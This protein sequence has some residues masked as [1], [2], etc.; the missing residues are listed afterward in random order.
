MQVR[1]AGVMGF[2]YGVRRAISSLEKAAHESAPIQTLG[3]VVHNRQVVE[4]LAARGIQPV[5][6]ISRLTCPT[7]AITTH[8]VGPKVMAE[9]QS[10]S[11]E[12]INVTCPWVKRAQRA[13]QRLTAAGFSVLILGDRGHPEVKGV[14]EWAGDAGRATDGTDIDSLWKEFPRRLGIMSQ[15][16]QNP[17]AFDEFVKR[18]MD[19]FLPQ[20]IELRVINTICD[21]TQK[22]QAAAIEL[23]GTVDVIV[24]VGGKGS[25]N[26]RRLAEICVASGVAARLIETAR[27]L[28]PNWFRGKQQVGVTAGAST[29]DEAI[30]EVIDR[31]NHMEVGVQCNTT[32]SASISTP[33]R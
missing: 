8:G 2:C 12:I 26:T 28:D 5:E 31:L 6:T 29:P 27:E 32:S 30:Q 13:A 23:A 16:T 24:V 22:R 18:A 4:R 17:Q 33:R 19:R 10:R 1:K 7:V 21:A 14:L 20:G 9:L 3:H 11:S 15:T 25:A